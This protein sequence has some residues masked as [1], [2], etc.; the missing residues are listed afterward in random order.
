MTEPVNQ[1]M[2]LRYMELPSQVAGDNVETPFLL[3]LDRC[4]EAQAE[5]LKHLPPNWAERTGAR[6]VLIFQDEI[7]IA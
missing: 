6:F 3:V 4:N 1:P 2:R 7:E 5:R